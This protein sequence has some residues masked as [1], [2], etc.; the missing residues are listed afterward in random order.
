MESLKQLVP[1]RPSAFARCQWCLS[2]HS[3]FS[4]SLW[5][6]L[7]PQSCWA[8]TLARGTHGRLG[9]G[10]YPWAA[11]GPLVKSPKPSIAG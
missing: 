4:V 1:A 8:L 3:T 11:L 5:T 2:F 7:W 6:D 9:C 10:C